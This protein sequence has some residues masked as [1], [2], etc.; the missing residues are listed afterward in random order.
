MPALDFPATFIGFAT[1][2]SHSGTTVNG[3]PSVP[4]PGAPTS[5]ADRY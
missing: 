2:F 4:W 3:E 5:D 1:M